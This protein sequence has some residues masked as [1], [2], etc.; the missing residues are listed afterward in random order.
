MEILSPQEVGK[1]ARTR[2]NAVETMGPVYTT[3][4]YSHLLPLS[5]SGGAGYARLLFRQSACTVYPLVD[6]LFL[7]HIFQQINAS[8]RKQNKKSSKNKKRH[9]APGCSSVYL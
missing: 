9:S 2:G 7:V 5:A 4:F 8:G 1:I 3:I 6:F